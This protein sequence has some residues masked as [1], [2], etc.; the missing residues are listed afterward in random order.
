MNRAGFIPN[1]SP[2][3]PQAC[4]IIKRIFQVIEYYCLGGIA[5]CP[6]L[7]RLEN[8]FDF[9]GGLEQSP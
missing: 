2:F 7:N 4:K 9:R 8:N 1:G 5:Y 3:G 6:K